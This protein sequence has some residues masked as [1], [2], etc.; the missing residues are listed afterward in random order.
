M[1]SALHVHG[2]FADGLHGVHV[3]QDVVLFGDFA[4]F[5][6]GLDDADFVIRVHDR[7]E[8]RF[9]RDRAA[10]IVEI[11]EPVL[12]DGQIGDFEARFLQALAGVE[13][14]LVLGRLRDDVIALFAIGF[15]DALEARLLDSVAPLVKTISRGVGVNQAGD[16]P[17]A[18]STASSAFHP[19]S[20]LRLAALPYFSV[21]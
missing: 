16:M 14:G 12:C 21:K 11:D 10:K 2:N 3:E 9:R 1:P 19:N 6:D 4:D 7:D 15:R 18:F 17:R 20:W 5:R 8:D 13:H